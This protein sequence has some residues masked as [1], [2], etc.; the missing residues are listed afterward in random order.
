[1]PESSSKIERLDSLSMQI[2]NL[3]VLVAPKIR[4]PLEH[5]STDELV[6]NGQTFPIRN[7]ILYLLPDGIE[8][9][10]IKEREREGWKR[11]FKENDWNV[12]GEHVLGLPESLND[13][14]WNK[15]SAAFKMVLQ[16]MQPLSGK[17]GLDVACGMGW[18]A[19][20]FAKLGARM[21]AAD[22]NDTVHNGLGAAIL[23]RNHGVN[24][25][26]VCSDCEYLPIADSSLDFVFICSALHHFTRPEVA[27]AEI[28]RVLKPGGMLAD[29]CESFKTGY[30]DEERE[31]GH[32]DLND[33]RAAGINEQTFTHAEYLR[34]FQSVGF[35]R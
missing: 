21:I 28:F 33:F 20:N 34:M 35:F 19:A 13:Q 8:N 7:G 17:R 5:L 18:G 16:A 23:V 25:D 30:G 32:K 6:S 11:V 4:Q 9:Q 15:V 2:H 1:M 26:A 10:E 12:N 22:F 14:Y 29:I 24:F 31:A 3:D 27:L